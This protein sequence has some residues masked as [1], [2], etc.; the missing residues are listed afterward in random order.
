MM[1]EMFFPNLHVV[2]I[3]KAFN[4]LVFSQKIIAVIKCFMKCQSDDIRM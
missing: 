2:Q 1:N 3:P 4:R